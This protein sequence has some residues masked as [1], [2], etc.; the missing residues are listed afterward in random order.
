[1]RLADGSQIVLRLLN[2][3]IEINTDYGKLKVPVAHIRRI[4][5]G[6]R[7]PEGVE[8]RVEGA[9]ARLRDADSKV[10]IAAGKE[11]VHL[12]ELAYPALLRAAKSADLE[13]KRQAAELVRELEDKVPGEL[14]W[15]RDRDIIVTTQFPIVGRIE[16]LSLK[17]HSRIF[18]QGQL[19]VDKHNA[20]AVADRQVG[21]RR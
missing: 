17:V 18:G 3:E 16:G 4:D 6:L 12:N 15:L 2:E 5:V 7:Y 11:L 13:F 1:M 10:R 21:G 19:A 14:L 9:L 8:K 20:G